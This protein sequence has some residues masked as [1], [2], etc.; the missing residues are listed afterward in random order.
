[1]KKTDMHDYSD[2]VELPFVRSPYNYNM[3]RAGDESGLA[4]LD[5]SLTQQHMADECDINKLV[6]RFVVTGEIPQLAMPPLQGDFTEVMTYQESLNLMIAA[7][8]SFMAM[9]AKVR[10]RFENDP[11]QFIEFC[12]NEANRD[13]MRQ[14]G[15][16]SVEANAAF[17][18]KAQTQR[19]LDAA[20]AA[21][22]AEHQKD[23]KKGKS[24]PEGAAD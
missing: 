23:S 12:S 19:D 1:M 11:G 7:K 5:K 15:L 16:W 20:N 13:E 21:Y 18:L 4:C 22:V 24:R 6:E 17:E 10:N 3:N 8:Q 2:R 14:M 9:P